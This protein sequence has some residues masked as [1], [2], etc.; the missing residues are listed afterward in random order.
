MESEF[1]HSLS[2]STKYDFDKCL[3]I[4]EILYKSLPISDSKQL[5]SIVTSTLKDS[6]IDLGITWEEGLFIRTGA[7]ILDQELVNE[8]L[9]WLSG[10]IYKNVYV[11]FEKGLTHFLQSEKRPELLSDV[12]TDMYESLEAL[13]KVVTGRTSKDLSANAELFIQKLKVS[14]SYK[15][16]LK[17]Y[18]SYANDFR[19]AIE[20]GKAR[21]RLS[22]YEVE[23]FIYLTGLF[24]R[25]A[26]NTA[27]VSLPNDT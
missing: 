22:I 17:D 7:K 12:I 23:S 10:P 27:E 4:L 26:K 6:E 13:A 16:I 21:P 25:L 24:I 1:P 20:Q 2:E 19:H 8:S 9:R 3:R 18:I 15:R 14:E 11:P 5:S